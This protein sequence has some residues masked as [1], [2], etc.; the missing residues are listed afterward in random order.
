MVIALVK[1]SVHSTIGLITKNEQEYVSFTST[2]EGIFMIGVLWW[3]L[4]FYFFINLPHT[5]CL[6]GFW[7]LARLATVTFLFLTTIRFE[8][9]H[10]RST[11]YSTKKK[12]LE[13]ITLIR[14]PPIIT[15]IIAVFGY[16]F[17]KQGIST[18]LPTFFNSK[19]LHITPT[20]SVE[21]AS[22]LSRAYTIWRLSTNFLLKKVHW[23]VLPV[24]YIVASAL[25]I[26]VL[27]CRPTLQVGIVNA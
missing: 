14:H 9:S 8:E 27:F 10:I 1:V 15:F 22:I 11:R 6:D 24:I 18:W 2:F 7:L 13:M 3:V 25:T 16:V 19:V 4:D 20:M 23:M 26:I 17:I 12:F 5:T 21:M